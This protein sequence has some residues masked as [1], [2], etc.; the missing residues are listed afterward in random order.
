M[1][2]SKG[3]CGVN[4]GKKKMKAF[5]Q[6]LTVTAQ[7]PCQWKPLAAQRDL[8]LQR[9]PS[10][11]SPNT[12]LATGLRQHHAYAELHSAEES[13]RG[14]PVPVL[15]VKGLISRSWFEER[16]CFFV[17]SC[18]LCHEEPWRWKLL[19]NT[20]GEEMERFPPRW[21]HSQM[22]AFRLGS[23]AHALRQRNFTLQF[24]RDTRPPLSLWCAIKRYLLS[25]LQVSL[26]E[27]CLK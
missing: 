6:T 10:R 17:C 22:C 1:L 24:L 11:F 23:P 12:E 8:L 19:A 15:G 26:K 25:L 2:G 14:I 5:L 13:Q 16:N 3:A 7:W 20:S 9:H 21:D 27:M 18:S 4:L